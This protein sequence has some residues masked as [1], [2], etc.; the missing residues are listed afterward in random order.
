M[1]NELFVETLK[2]LLQKTGMIKGKA[3]YLYL[4]NGQLGLVALNTARSRKGRW[5]ELDSKQL[6]FSKAKWMKKGQ[7]QDIRAEGIPESRWQLA[8]ELAQ[9]TKVS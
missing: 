6:Y 5:T 1:D 4:E 9:A 2:A 3:G 7:V 8:A